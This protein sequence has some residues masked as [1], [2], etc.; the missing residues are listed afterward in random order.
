[1]SNLYFPILGAEVPPMLGRAKIMQRLWDDLTK[2]SPSHLSIVG[3]R[4]A[5]KSVILRGLAERMGKQD[6][7][8]KAVI[9]WDL[10]HQTPVSDEAFY[11]LLCRRIGEGIK[12]VSPLYSEH[13]LSVDSDEYS[14]LREV[15]DALKQDG[16]NLLMLWDGFDKPLG[17][18]KLTRNL[19]D[20]LRELASSP[21]LRLVTATRRTLHELIRSTE[22]QASDFWNIFDLKPVKVEVFDA[23]DHDDILK[24]IPGI[25]FSTGAMN[26]LENWTA[27]YPPL[28]LAVLNKIIEVN[29]ASEVDNLV[30]NDAAGKALDGV[31]HILNDLWSD[32]PE[33]AK[34]LY[35]HLVEHGERLTS[36][37]GKIESAVLTEKG[38]VRQ[39]GNKTSKGCRLLELH[40]QN[41]GKDAS[42]I[43]RLFGTSEDYRTNVRSLLEVRFS[44]LRNFD[45]TFLRFIERSIED[46]PDNPEVCLA[47]IRGIVDRAL[48]LIWEAELGS[49]HKIPENY[50]SD[51]H[52]NGEKGAENYW[53]KKFPSKRGHQ[54][55]LLQL[56]TGTDKSAAKATRVS[57]NTYA[58]ASAAHGFGDFGQHIDSPVS[59]GVA[60]AAVTIC[61]ELA[62]CLDRELLNS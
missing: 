45:K 17:T 40:L 23:A 19:W 53:D 54:I 48:D 62:A 22:S 9:L 24:K 27:G 55:R 4:Y 43:V 60:V 28:Y 25:T 8:Y 20:N 3:P 5:G 33:K 35:R 44:Q 49:D 51:W 32:C 57:K 39:S 26:E 10:G 34:D 30:V 61:L 47:N 59:L 46:I 1:M 6:S 2:P 14:E 12:A 38:F 29:P 13:L 18:G 11:K 52:Y 42:S 7:P 41:Q 21:N 31:V 50:F 56:L 15:L 36:E 16:I 37:V 58:L